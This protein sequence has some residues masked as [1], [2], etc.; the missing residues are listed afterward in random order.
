M[1]THHIKKS[2]S[3][4]TKLS[5]LIC[6][7]YDLLLVITRFGI[8]LGFGEKSIREVCE[9]NKVNTNTLMAVINALINRPEHPSETVLSDLSAPSLINYL[10][11]SHNYFLEFRLPLLRQ[12]LFAALTNCPS[13]VV[14]VIRQ[15]YDEYVEE[16]RKHMSYE[17]KTV[18]PYVEKLLGGKLDKRSHYRIDIFSKRHDQIELKISELKNLLI[19]YYP[20]S[21]GYE[22]NSVLHDIFS[23]EDDLSAHNFVED[24]LFV[25]LIRKIEKENGL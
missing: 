24:H 6:E 1:T 11:K 7:N 23:S 3:P 4:N 13:E 20:T 22:L 15:F 9:D 18:F 16:V 25:P 17:E 14:F 5:D 19:K 12:D 10:R 21:S 8:S 2:Y